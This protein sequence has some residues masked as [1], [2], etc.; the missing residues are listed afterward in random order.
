MMIHTNERSQ[1]L[2]T[3]EPA[4]RSHLLPAV[5]ILTMALP[6]STRTMGIS[7]AKILYK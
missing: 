1:L 5:V 4:A 2:V 6:L 7:H 3:E